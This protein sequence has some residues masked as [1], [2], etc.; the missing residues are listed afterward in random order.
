MTYT[1]RWLSVATQQLAKLPREV[2]KRIDEATFAL[3][4]DPRGPSV[5]H[6]KG[7]GR[8]HRLRVGEYRVIF[9]ID[10]QKIEVLVLSVGA[11]KE[12]YR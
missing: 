12:A 3:S 5:I 6:M 10:D 2:A 11:R 4:N 9:Q 1:V 8:P 7:P